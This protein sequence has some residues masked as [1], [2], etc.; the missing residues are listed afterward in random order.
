MLI[1]S[2]YAAKIIKS[3]VFFCI[4]AAKIIKNIIIPNKKS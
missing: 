1:Y 2:F 4:F 3:V